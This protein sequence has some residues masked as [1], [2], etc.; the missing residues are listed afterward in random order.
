MSSPL[1]SL[2]KNKKAPLPEVQ[3]QRRRMVPFKQN[4]YTGDDDDPLLSEILN[5]KIKI[6]AESSGISVMMKT[7]T[8]LQ[9]NNKKELVPSDM[10]LL[11]SLMQRLN[12]LEQREKIQAQEIKQKDKQIAALEERLQIMQRSQEMHFKPS[13]EEELEK[14]CRHLQN[15]VWE[16][17]K[18]LNDYGMIWVGEK[19]DQDGEL[20]LQE[21]REPQRKN[22]S[23]ERLWQPDS[24][25]S[26]KFIVDFD[27]VLEN[28]RDLNI[29]AGEGEAHV[30]HIEGGARLRHVNPV[31]LTLYRNG[32]FLFNGPFRSYTEPSTQQFIRDIMDGYF[33]SEL[34]KM[35]PEGIPFQVTDNRNVVFSEKSLWNMF[36]GGGQTVDGQIS[37]LEKDDSFMSITQTSEVP[38]PR[39]SMEQFLNKLPKAVI[40]G[41][42]VIDI[43]GAI[44]G[45]LQGETGSSGSDAVILIE[46]PALTA[47]KERLMLDEESRPPSSKNISTLRVKSENGE[48]TYIVKMLFTETI[49]DLR[50]YL[51]KHR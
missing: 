22:Q 35:Y 44:K 16:M 37:N 30:E 15:Q 42:K 49:G 18:F 1:S 28:I 34:Q 8:C 20:Y 51:N 40:R 23:H 29:L 14:K 46:T 45:S 41:G 50:N 5:Q 2:G 6:P 9:K 43:R 10:E 48:Q 39:I 36:P 21:E 13:R 3:N 7:K 27:L 12:R 32:I 26:A 19:H 11:S 25:T 24:S 4:T 38:G 17:E 31:S 33:P 47:M